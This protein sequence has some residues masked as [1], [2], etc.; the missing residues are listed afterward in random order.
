MNEASVISQTRDQ[1]SQPGGSDSR[2][3]GSAFT[4]K[5]SHPRGRETEEVGALELLAPRCGARA[6]PLSSPLSLAKSASD[7][8]S[9][10]TCR[11]AGRRHERI[12]TRCALTGDFKRCVLRSRLC[13]GRREFSLA[14]GTDM[15][16]CAQAILGSSAYPRR[17]FWTQS[18]GFPSRLRMSFVAA[19]KSRRRC[20]SMWKPLLRRPP[21]PECL[22]PRRSTDRFIGDIRPALR[23]QILDIPEAKDEAKVQPQPRASDVRRELAASERDRHGGICHPR[24]DALSICGSGIDLVGAA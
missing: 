14:R 3:W 9:R 16:C 1:K 2:G 13:T 8:A 18:P 21:E 6:I 15:V 22:P 19:L 10:S 20:T 5:L 23:E 24:D 11:P 7:C 4:I 12:A 17:A